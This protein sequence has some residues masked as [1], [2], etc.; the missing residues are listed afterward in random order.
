MYKHALHRLVGELNK[1]GGIC[2]LQLYDMH[3]CVTDVYGVLL[4]TIF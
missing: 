1:Y 4:S 2:G 3:V